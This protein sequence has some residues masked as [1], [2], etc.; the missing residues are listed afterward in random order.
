MNVREVLIE[1]LKDAIDPLSAGIAPPD[2][3]AILEK[4]E[5]VREAAL[6]QVEADPGGLTSVVSAANVLVDCA[7]GVLDAAKVANALTTLDPTGGWEAGLGMLIRTGKKVRLAG[8]EAIGLS[9]MQW[10]KFLDVFRERLAV[11]A[12]KQEEDELWEELQDGSY[13]LPIEDISLADPSGKTSA[14]VTDDGEGGAKFQRGDPTQEV[15]DALG[16][17]WSELPRETPDTDDV[18]ALL[19]ACPLHVRQQAATALH[20]P[21][22]ADGWNNLLFVSR[23]PTDEPWPDHGCAT[24]RPD[25]EDPSLPEAIHGPAAAATEDVRVLPI[26]YIRVG[27]RSVECGA[28]VTARALA[29]LRQATVM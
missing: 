16:L 28:A 5:A 24:A 6:Q 4:L 11:S 12:N 21:N 13:R 23:L 1:L 7:R 26:G 20:C 14:W 17:D 10:R 18:R 9:A 25:H 22:G 8:D 29:R 27:R 19:L 15:Y 3:A 2:W